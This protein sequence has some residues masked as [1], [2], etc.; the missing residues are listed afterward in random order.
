MHGGGA[1]PRRPAEQRS[2]GPA[3]LGVLACPLRAARSGMLA[4]AVLAT[5]ACG[6]PAEPAKPPPQEV[7]TDLGPRLH[8]EFVTINNQPLSSATLAGRISVLGFVATYDVASQ[9]QAR[10]LT[11]LFR[12]HKPRLNV[13]LLIL[14]PPENQPMVE[15]FAAALGVPYPVAM[16]DAATIAGRGPFA[17]LHH[18]PSVVILDREGREAWRRMG[19]VGAEE[20]ENAVREIERRSGSPAPVTATP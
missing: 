19:L 2:S 4:V 7:T 15:A 20:L 10:F 12:S 1:R 14:E 17:G 11:G 3:G 16:A 5:L 13:A 8:F 9:A 18:V 6:G